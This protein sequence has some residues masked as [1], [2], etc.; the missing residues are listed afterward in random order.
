MKNKMFLLLKLS[1]LLLFDN[2]YE[3]SFFSS[4]LYYLTHRDLVST[5]ATLRK[6]SCNINIY[7]NKIG[8]IL[9]TLPV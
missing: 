6:Y 9:P 2:C 4:S 7:N 8:R 5:W 3:E 1:L